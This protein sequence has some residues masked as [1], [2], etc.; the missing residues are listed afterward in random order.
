[1]HLGGRDEVRGHFAAMMDAYRGQGAAIWSPV[2]IESHPL[3]E[4]ARFETVRW[5]ALDSDGKV[6]R[7]TKTTYQLLATPEEAEGWRFL[8]YTNH[9]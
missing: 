9:F 6:L 1:M 5:N 7:D 8:S 4:H 3:G 2:E